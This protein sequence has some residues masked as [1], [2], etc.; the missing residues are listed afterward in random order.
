MM[1]NDKENLLIWQIYLH[2]LEEES[3]L[4][5]QVL[6]LCFTHSH[7]RAVNDL[8]MQLLSSFYLFF[9]RFVSLPLSSYLVKK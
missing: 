1:A 8:D 7:G 5:C 4:C 2:G 9:N 3:F 6:W